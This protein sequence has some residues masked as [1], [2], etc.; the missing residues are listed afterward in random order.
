MDNIIIPIKRNEEGW[1]KKLLANLRQLVLIEKLNNPVGITALTVLFLLVGLGIAKLGLVFGV[2]CMIVVLAL[3]A[4]YTIVMYPRVG[5]I[6]YLTMA[7]L[8]MW[9]LRLGVNFPLGTLMDGME[10]LFILGLLIRQKQKPDWKI[11]KGP[12]S[13]WIL[14]WI[15]Y[16]LLEFANPTAESR[17]AWV[18]T[19]RSVAVVMFMY[20]IF[21]YNIRTKA[22]VKL[23]IKLWL[24]LAFFGAAYAF[25]QEHFG[26]F[27]FEEA[28]LHSDPNIA[29]LLFIG[30]VWRKFSIFSD[31]VV[32]SYTMVV[33]SMLCVGLLTG[34]LSLK[35]KL[36]LY[37]L[38]AFFLLNMLYSGT[39]GADVL[40]PVCLLL[41]AILKYNKKVLVILLIG[42]GLMAALIFMPT[43]NQ[44]LGRFQSAFKPSNDA[45]FNVRK[46]N[47]KRI[48]PY[49]WSH[50]LGG[51]LGATG[52]WGQRFAPYSFL[53]SFPPDSGYVRVAVELGSIGL[54][55][56]CM[57][58]FTIL[59]V[60]INNY[61][62]IKDPQLKSF[63]LAMVL[64]V[65][66]FNIGNYPQEALVQF[67]S[68]VYFYLV[69]ALI[70]VIKRID[71]QQNQ[72]LQ[73]GQ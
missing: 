7:Y 58:M 21:V 68:N 2:L 23:I 65:F 27:P 50:P 67:P 1:R 59:R 9:F 69:T 47:Q 45:S 38:I 20:F 19:V 49:I 42:A 51:G 71:D 3:P 35:K 18:Y 39:R 30:G 26:F 54:F 63:C 40:P 14:V 10:G 28:Y 25:K 36:V 66:A 11:F 33:S 16:N 57:L 56:F 53:A 17:L 29:L 31:P 15:S 34:P 46:I 48:Q 12:I 24:G 6:I 32:F 43:G 72:Q 13:I 55:L 4:V 22:Y 5:M 52:E 41:L 37:F 70:V 64:I 73:H 61:Y 60:G 44:T 8:I 62:S